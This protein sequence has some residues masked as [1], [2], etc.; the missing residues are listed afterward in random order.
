MEIFA[1]AFEALSRSNAVLP[2]LYVV[3]DKIRVG[4]RTS[5]DA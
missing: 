3:P 4:S 2:L 5:C 1:Q